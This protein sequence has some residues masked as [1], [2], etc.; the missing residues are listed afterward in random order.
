MKTIAESLL[1]LILLTLASAARAAHD[2]ADAAGSKDPALF[3]RMPHFHIYSSETKEFDKYDFPTSPDNKV[4]E[5]GRS[6]ALMYYANDN[7][8]DKLPSP[9]QIVRNYTNAVKAINGKVVYEYEDGGSQFATL[10]LVKDG[11][12][13]WVAVGASQNGSYNVNI[14]EKQAMTQSVVADASSLLSSIRG[15]GK[16]AV[17]GIYFDTAKADI[18]PASAPALKEIAKLLKLD[19]ALN[20]YVVGHTDGVGI[21]ASNIR[22]SKNRAA[23][24][25]S[26]LTAEY[27]IA[28]ERLQPDGV[29]PLCPAD[30]NLTETGRAKNRRMEL[31]AK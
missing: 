13:T 16:A 21:F 20:L 29:G 1:F 26:S 6:Q 10:K 7:I 28:A 30:T 24:V 14:I 2:P 5:E 3:S 8:G 23:S 12:E 19:T 25:V 27:G 18:K 15:T 31:V 4:S 22:L 11:A 17:Y 9:L